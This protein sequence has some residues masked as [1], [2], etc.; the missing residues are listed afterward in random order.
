VTVNAGSG[1][2]APRNY[3]LELRTDGTFQNVQRSADTGSGV[4][5]LGIVPTPSDAGKTLVF[6][7]SIQ[8]GNIDHVFTVSSASSIWMSLK[9]DINGDGNLDESTGFV[10]LRHS[11]VRPPTV[12]FVVGLPS[13]SPG[14][15]VPSM[16]FRVG[17]ALTYTSVARFVIW[18]TTINDLEGR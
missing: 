2:T 5:P 16:N 12:P 15:L 18:T 3:R 14:P 13:G 4:A 17:S 1:W 9:Y 11:M 7:G 8:N 6:E 10:Y